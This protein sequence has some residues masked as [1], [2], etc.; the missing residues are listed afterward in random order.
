MLKDFRDFAMRG[1][2]IDM[3]VGIVLGASFGGI[4]TSLVNDVM[5]PP[6]GLVLGRVDFSNLFISLTGRHFDTVAAAKTAS[7]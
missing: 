2:I 3:A 7:S 6:I 5:M 1:N 4:V